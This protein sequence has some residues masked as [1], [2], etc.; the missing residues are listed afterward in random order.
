MCKRGENIYKRKDNR[1]EGRY[2]IIQPDGTKKYISI[3]AKSYNEIKERLSV[4]KEQA[5]QNTLNLPKCRLTVQNLLTDWLAA[6]RDTVKLSSFLRYEMLIKNQL[7]PELGNIRLDKLTTKK[8]SAF[9]QQKQQAGLLD[10][11]GGLSAKTITDMLFIIKSAFKMA[12]VQ[13]DLPQAAAIAEIKAPNCQQRPV[14]TFSDYE[15]KIICQRILQRP[16]TGNLAILLALNTGLRLGEVCAL[17]WHDIDFNSQTLHIRRNVQRA[18]IKGKSQLLVQTP[19]SQSSQRVIPLTAE[20]LLLLKRLQNVVGSDYVFG[21]VRPLEPRTLQY[22]LA[23][24]L[25]ECNIRKRNFHI[26]R[27]TFATRFIAAGADVKSLSEILGH[28][29]VNITM[30]LYVH[31]TMA[32]K[33]ANMETINILRDLC[34]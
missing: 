27:H 31:P 7:I 16:Q 3:Y 2:Y 28:A 8:L 19:K 12:A 13:Y 11:Q 15:V 10:K 22:R 34:A 29:K 6:K 14:E 24:L 20:I 21:G 18:T 9:I 23:Y 1:W 5:R 25:K 33:R 26:L 30:Q 17:Q 4:C 32:Q